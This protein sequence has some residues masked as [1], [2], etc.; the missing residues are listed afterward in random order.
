MSCKGFYYCKNISLVSTNHPVQGGVTGKS[1]WKKS[2]GSI[3]QLPSK[4]LWVHSRRIWLQN[5]PPE[6]QLKVPLLAFPLN[7]SF[8][9]GR[10]ASFCVS[11]SMAC[12]RRSLKLSRIVPAHKAVFTP[13]DEDTILLLIHNASLRLLRDCLGGTVV[14]LPGW[15]NS[16][17]RQQG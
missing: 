9:E 15:R 10:E 5:I 1:C 13:M 7:E 16:K 14:M 2:F 8:G 12:I 17:S 3:F 11:A 4:C 6:C